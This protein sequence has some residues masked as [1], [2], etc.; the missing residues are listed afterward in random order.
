MD[1]MTTAEEK[2]IACLDYDYNVSDDVVIGHLRLIE[3]VDG[4]GE[5]WH[6]EG[7]SRRYTCKQLKMISMKLSELNK[8]L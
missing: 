5:F 4:D 7:E 2:A 1:Y 6:F 8:A 3:D